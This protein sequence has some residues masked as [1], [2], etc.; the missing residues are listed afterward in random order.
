MQSHWV[1]SFMFRKEKAVL[2]KTYTL[3]KADTKQHNEGMQAKQRHEIKEK[4]ESY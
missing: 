2:V 4:L 1:C 3:P